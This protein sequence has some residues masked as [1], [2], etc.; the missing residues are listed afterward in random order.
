MRADAGGSA[1][2]HL[3]AVPVQRSDAAPGSARARDDSG[4]DA[5]SGGSNGSGGR[6]PFKRRTRYTARAAVLLLVFCGVVLALAYPLQQYVQQSSQ[7]DKLEQQNTAKRRQLAQLEQQLQDWKDPAFV[8]IMAR[9]RLHY[10]L[11]GETGLTL[12][13]GNSGAS[14]ST[15]ASGSGDGPSAWYGRLWDSVTE[16]ASPGGA[17]VPAAGSA[18]KTA[19]TGASGAAGATGAAGVA[20]VAGGAGKA[21][22]KP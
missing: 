2:R 8:E 21:A 22:A 19:A 14:G 3:S 15:G 12:V 1:P 11:P 20:G 5:G 18:G 9:L 4:D 16:A 17:A 6:G 7:L 13:G 10:V